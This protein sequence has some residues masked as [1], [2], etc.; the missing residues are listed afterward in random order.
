MPVILVFV[1]GLVFG[2]TFSFVLIIA[3]E[4]RQVA[5]AYY[6]NGLDGKEDIRSALNGHSPNE[7]F[8]KNEDIVAAKL[9]KYI[10]VLCLVVTAPE[11][12]NTKTVAVN[13]TWGKRCSR[14]LFVSN[15]K[16]EFFPLIDF[17][18]PVGKQYVW[19]LAKE[20]F[21]HVY[22]YYLGTIDWIVRADDDTFVVMENLHYLLSKYNPDDAL[23]LGCRFKKDMTQGFM[24]AGSGYVLSREAV[25]RL[26][27]QT[28]PNKALCA[29][30]NE[31]I[32]EEEIGRC[33]E[34]A[35]VTAVDTRDAKGRYRFFPFNMETH[36]IPGKIANDSRFWKTIYYP[37]KTGLDCCSDTAIS[38]NSM[39]ARRMIFMEYM[40]YHL[41]PYGISHE[42]H[43]GDKMHESVNKTESA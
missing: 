11:N 4:Q 38:F 21:K 20:A 35:N 30:G 6:S 40:L 22:Q 8:H 18:V 5:T 19:G 43:E 27:E 31:G 26:V 24:S 3:N 41:H 29:D 32:E 28:I 1:T 14:L 12:F 34:N 42:Q 9:S 13:Q 36:I 25:K 39:D 17:P 37:Y 33:L 16:N 7:E 15:K 23:Y 10:K 2:I